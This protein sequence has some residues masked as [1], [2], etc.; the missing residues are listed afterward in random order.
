M[1]VPRVFVL[2]GGMGHSGE[3]LVRTAL[4]QFED[5]DTPVIVVAGVRRSEQLRQ[6]VDEAVPDCDLVVHTLVD[7]ELRA[8]LERMAGD[9]DVAAVDVMGPLLERMSGLLGRRPLGRPGLYRSLREDY[10]RRVEAI[11]FAVMHDDGAR[12]DELRQADVVLIGVSRAGKT[13]LSMFLAMRG[14]KVANVPLVRQVPPPEELF[15][16]ERRRV[17][18]LTLEPE[19][20]VGFRRQRHRTLGVGSAT[21]YV[22]LREIQAELDHA[23]EIFRRGRF[24]VVDVT[25]RPIEETANEVLGHL[26]RRT[27]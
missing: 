9:A 14:H 18:G 15:E 2:S 3:Q 7:E 4:A 26:A 17:I 16:I 1:N 25:S 22:D 24:Y 20:L 12:P 6:V 11:E 10:F 5:G 13:P 23:R 21:S 27:G 19:R 8:D